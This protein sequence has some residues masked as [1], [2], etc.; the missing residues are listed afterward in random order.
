MNTT[1]TALVVV[2]LAGLP[3]LMCC[4]G[5]G[6]KGSGT[7][8]S[9]TRDLPTFRSVELA[10]SGHVHIRQGEH[11]SVSV[12]TDDNIMPLVKTEVR[13][14]TLV[15]SVEGMARHVTSLEFDIVVK[16]ITGLRVSGS[17]DIV[18]RG[19]FVADELDVG[20]RGSGRVDLKVRAEAVDARISGSGDVALSGHTDVLLIKVSGSGDVHAMDMTTRT[21]RVTISGSGDCRAN[22]LDELDVTVSGSGAVY[23]GGDPRLTL[24]VSGSGS[25]KRISG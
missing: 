15:L 6:A 2:G 12:R 18:G 21:A 4:T 24:D 23:Y 5:V 10:G 16:E 20:V 19:S 14:E 3:L 8:V 22:V 13:G 17:G 9:E 7:L 25:V 1:A 11:Q